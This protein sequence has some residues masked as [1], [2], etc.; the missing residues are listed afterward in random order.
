MGGEQIGVSSRV[1]DGPDKCFIGNLPTAMV[2]SDIQALLETFGQLKGFNLVTHAGTGV[3]RGFGFFKYR[4]PNITIPAVSSLNGLEL[5]GNKLTCQLCSSNQ[6]SAA[7]TGDALLMQQLAQLN[8]TALAGMVP[9]AIPTQV[10]CMQNMVTAEELADDEEYDDIVVDVNEECGSYGTVASLLVPRPGTTKPNLMDK[11][12]Y[13]FLF[14]RARGF[15]SLLS[16]FRWDA[17]M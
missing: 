17:F 12:R 3:S 7:V 10:I 6:P 5:G 16:T 4:D 13:S 2:A 8:A 9:G 14:N 11:V 15:F 1:D